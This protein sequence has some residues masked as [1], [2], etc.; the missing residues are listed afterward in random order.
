MAP[1]WSE[2]ETHERGCE[3]DTAALIDASL[4]AGDLP[5]LADLCARF[6]PAPETLPQVT[7]HADPAQR[8]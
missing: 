4:D 2:I 3:A 6:V 7:G 5:D 8:L 1:F